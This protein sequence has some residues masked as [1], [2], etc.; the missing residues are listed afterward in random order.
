MDLPSVYIAG[1]YSAG[2]VALNVRNAIE[3]AEQVITLNCIP[4]VPHLTHFWHF[5][6]PHT[7]EWWLWYDRQWLAK[8]DYLLRL[9]G[10]SN[11]ADKEVEEAKRLGILVAY[12]IDQL[13][14]MST[15]DAQ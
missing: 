8:C 1:P 3:A 6:Q 13:R 10:A 4:Y 2:D 7:Y 14:M 12:G 15:A 9:P 11:G 5:A